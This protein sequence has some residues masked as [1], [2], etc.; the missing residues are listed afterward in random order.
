MIKILS[1]KNKQISKICLIN[2]K[3]IFQTTENIILQLKMTMESYGK[4]K[5]I[6]TI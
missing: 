5:H 6:W 3:T 1:E 2:K 4:K